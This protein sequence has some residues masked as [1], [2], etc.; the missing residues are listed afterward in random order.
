MHGLYNLI[1]TEEIN[2]SGYLGQKS[3]SHFPHRSQHTLMTRIKNLPYASLVTCLKT[4]REVID[5]YITRYL[6]PLKIYNVLDF[7]GILFKD[8]SRTLLLS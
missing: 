5:P 3:I 7:S 2:S 6:S 4:K 1:S 8:S